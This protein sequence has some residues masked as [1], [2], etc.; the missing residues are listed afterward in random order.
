MYQI[1]YIT[2]VIKMDEF[3]IGTQLMLV[4][5]RSIHISGTECSLT[6]ILKNGYG[7][8]LILNE[9]PGPV[10]NM[11]RPAVR[12]CKRTTQGSVLY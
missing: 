3:D 6:A 12:N 2:V 8:V 5:D 7:D 11:L 9:H 1:Q 4:T 10:S